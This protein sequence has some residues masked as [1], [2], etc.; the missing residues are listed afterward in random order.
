M[1]NKLPLEYGPKEAEILRTLIDIHKLP[2]KNEA[3]RRGI[4]ASDYLIDIDRESLFQILSMLLSIASDSAKN[5]YGDSFPRKLEACKSMAYEIVATFAV[6]RGIESADSVDIFRADIDNYLELL[7]QKDLTKINGDEL[8]K[9]LSTL[10]EIANQFAKKESE[11]RGKTSYLV[12][13]S[14]SSK[15]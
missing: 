15:Y 14:G 1:Q 3:F 13:V 4:V 8:A 11:N 12:A 10:S 2:S 9:R 7:K 6:Q 5:K